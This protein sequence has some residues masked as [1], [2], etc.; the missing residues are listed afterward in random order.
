[1]VDDIVDLGDQF[2]R[3]KVLQIK[4]LVRPALRHTVVFEDNGLPQ[5]EPQGDIVAPSLSKL[6]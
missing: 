5:V 6:P 4:Y 3:C 1:M 2:G